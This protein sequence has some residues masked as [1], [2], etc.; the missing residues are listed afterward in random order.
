M[1]HVVEVLIAE[2]PAAPVQAVSRVLAI[3]GVGLEGD[4]YATGCGTFSYKPHR[5]DG[6]LTLIGREHIDEF[7]ARTGIQFTV[8]RPVEISSL[9]EWI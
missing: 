9:W 1:A 4:R 2:S 6:E 5:P 3:P 8:V 7:S